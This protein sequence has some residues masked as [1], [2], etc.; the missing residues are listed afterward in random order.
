[1][2]IVSR[3]NT[4]SKSA[5]AKAIYAEMLASDQVFTRKQV[6]DRFIAEAE[7]T[8][9]GAASYYQKLTKKAG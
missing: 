8:K 1:M 7:L 2:A 4:D 3:N 5:K 9:T 6:L